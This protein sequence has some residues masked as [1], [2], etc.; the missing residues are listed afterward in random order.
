[1]T[2][3]LFPNMADMP[4]AT[5]GLFSDELAAKDF[6]PAALRIEHPILNTLSIEGDTA[7]VTPQYGAV[8][9][10]SLATGKPLHD[11]AASEARV[12]TLDADFAADTQNPPVYLEEVYSDYSAVIYPITGGAPVRIRTAADTVFL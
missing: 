10:Y 9:R 7:T 1:M 3:G 6:T 5:V 12:R 4:A 8:T 2:F 11:S